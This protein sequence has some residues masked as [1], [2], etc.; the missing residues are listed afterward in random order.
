MRFIAVLFGFVFLSILTT[1]T[2]CTEKGTLGGL[3][4]AQGVVTLDGAPLAEANIMFSPVGGGEMR[5]ASAKTDSNGAFT[6]TTL[7]P[8]DGVTPGKFTV[9]VVKYEKYGPAPEKVIDENGDDVT[10]A[11]PERNI[12]PEGYADKH[13]SGLEVAIPAGGDKNIQIKLEN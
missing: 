6:M 3:A 8:Q 5:A 12:L 2:G 7:K 4:P 11:H 10:P 9:T 1:T 13:T